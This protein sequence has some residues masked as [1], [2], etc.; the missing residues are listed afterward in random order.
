[1]LKLLFLLVTIGG[2]SSFNLA[3]ADESQNVLRIAASE[4]IAEQKLTELKKKLF[5]DSKK[6][7]ACLNLNAKM[8][9]EI[10]LVFPEYAIFLRSIV[11]DLKAARTDSLQRK[12]HER[13]RKKGMGERI[14]NAMQHKYKKPWD[15]T[16]YK[17]WALATAEGDRAIVDCESEGVS[18]T[19]RHSYPFQFGVWLEV[20]GQNELGRVYIS[21]VPSKNRWIIGGWLNQQWTH[22]G[23]DYL[24]WVEQG[25][26]LVKLGKKRDGFMSLDIAY[27]LLHGEEFM[28]FADKAKILT[29]RDEAGSTKSWPQDLN[30]IGNRSSVVYAATMFAEEGAGL[31]VR[32]RVDESLSTVDLRKQCFS[33]GKQLIS[34]GWLNSN[35][36]GL[37]CSFITKTEPVEKDGLLGGMYFTQKQILEAAL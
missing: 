21:I 20:M 17:S 24:A 28:E 16:V 8:Q 23:K 1:M 15:V 26:S 12:F 7:P 4:K 22:A 19:T 10:D 31:L 5:P 33:L 30:K 37:Y 6:L 2:V 11:D 18:L 13:I 9:K 36:A 27:K 35:T 25:Q 3:H 29:M 14:F 34:S 32:E